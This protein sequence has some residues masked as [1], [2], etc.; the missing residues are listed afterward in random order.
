[1][2]FRTGP[3]CGCCGQAWEKYVS[4]SLH[5]IFPRNPL[6]RPTV[7]P[8]VEDFYDPA[9]I[10][11]FTGDATALNHTVGW[12]S[13][14][15]MI[16]HSDTDDLYRVK[17]YPPFDVVGVL[18]SS[19]S[20]IAVRVASAST[21]IN[22]IQYHDDWGYGISVTG[23][24]AVD[25]TGGEDFV[26]DSNGMRV[27]GS[28]DITYTGADTLSNICTD[29]EGNMYWLGF[30]IGDE[31]SSVV[32]RNAAEIV[33][34][35]FPWVQR[36]GVIHTGVSPYVAYAKWDID[37][38]PEPTLGVYRCGSTVELDVELPYQFF[39]NYYSEHFKRAYGYRLVSANPYAH[40]LSYV[41]SNDRF[42]EDG[43]VALEQPSYFVIEWQ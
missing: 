20:D 34:D 17:P 43:I 12:C 40:R 37:T 23:P 2:S 41:P 36:Y 13:N 16:L 31:Q 26:F 9:E 28:S 42:L 18:F 22:A 35:S 4:D 32:G 1:M 30:P 7:H 38:N 11:S 19:S 15:D 29:S 39:L 25:T 21:Y 10:V 24:L 8:Q 3:C 27:R 33:S 5:R 6:Y 14:G